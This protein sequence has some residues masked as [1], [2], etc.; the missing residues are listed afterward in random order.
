MQL[1]L[2]FPVSPRFTLANFVTCPGNRTA[3][4]FTQ[5]LLDPGQSDNLLY[6]YGPAGAGKTHLIHA[7][8]HELASTCG[9]APVTVTPADRFLHQENEYKDSA[10]KALLLDDLH[11]FP[12]SS[13]ARIALWQAFNDH[14]ASGHPIVI[15]A[16]V[17]PKELP[18]FDGHMASR[19]LWGLVAR[20]D[21]LDDEARRMIMTKLAEDHQTIL[22][23]EVIEYLISH[24]PRDVSSLAEAVRVLTT[25][26]LSSHRKI[27]LKLVR[28]TIPLLIPEHSGRPPATGA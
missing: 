9:G 13:D 1:L 12:D 4:L 20:I 25:A 15:T 2:D 6:L 3:L 14:Y 26:S 7:I 27:T 19:L 17:P 23:T 22:P 8:A 24:L 5:R 18:C 10:P 28:E 16:S 11:L 21:T